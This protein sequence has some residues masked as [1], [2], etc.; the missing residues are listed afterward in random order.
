MRKQRFVW[1][2]IIFCFI[3]F[4]LLAYAGS[5]VEEKPKIVISV[6]LEGVAHVV[7][8]AS[9]PGRYYYDEARELVTKEINAAIEGCLEAGAGEIVVADNHG[10][11]LAVIPEKLHEA[12]LLARGWPR[13]LDLSTGIDENT[14][15]LILL[16]FHAK[17][18]TPEANTP[19]TL[20]GKF[21]V[22]INGVYVSEV[23]FSAA[24]AGEYD[25][26]VIMV[27]GD[28]HVDQE[29]KKY[30]GP[31]E[32]VVTKE[33][34][35]YYSAQS[36]HP[37]VIRQQ[38]KEKSKRAVQRLKEFKPFRFEP[39]ITMEFIYQKAF[40]AEALSYFPWFKRKDGKTVV[41]ELKS[42]KEACNIILGL[43][44]INVR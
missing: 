31:V 23:L 29:A 24:L 19:H 20:L 12:A 2:F 15:G 41:V 13:P 40:D 28:Q 16:G 6:D 25:V 27:T 26:P 33:S 43:A 14:A 22:I 44:S 1:H 3:V 5:Q 11:S 8:N 21:D 17:E 18:G 35:A 38:I 37:K 39:P 4:N 10:N 34:F 9:G 7:D 36:P 30:F 32:T 42:M